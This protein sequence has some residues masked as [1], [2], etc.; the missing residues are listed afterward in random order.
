MVNYRTTLSTRKVEKLTWFIHTKLHMMFFVLLVL[1]M[2]HCGIGN[3]Q[4]LLETIEALHPNVSAN[5]KC[6]EEEYFAYVYGIL[7]LVSSLTY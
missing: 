7:V 5:S 4:A 2:V 1:D 6:Y 3:S